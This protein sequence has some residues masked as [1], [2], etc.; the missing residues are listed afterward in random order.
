MSEFCTS[1]QR[2]LEKAISEAESWG[3]QFPRR[4][5]AK[6]GAIG[7]VAYNNQKLGSQYLAHRKRIS[8]KVPRLLI[9][10]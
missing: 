4:W 10:D 9:P 6:Y 1:T 2:L 5:C 8:S 7:H 3:D